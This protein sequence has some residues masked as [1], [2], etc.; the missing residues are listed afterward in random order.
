MTTF[1]K[2]T[3][4]VLTSVL[5]LSLATFA[6]AG[7]AR[8]GDDAG[9]VIAGLVGLAVL[10]AVISEIEKDNR[11]ARHAPAPVH[12][13]VIKP[14]P[15]PQDVHGRRLPL[16]CVRSDV[17][18]Q[19]NALLAKGCLKRHY[20]NADRLPR[21]CEVRYWNQKRADVRKGYTLNCLQHHGYRLARH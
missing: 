15:L 16:R 2:L 7:P 17:S 20:Q 8:A 13:P 18:Q 14:R 21:K 4:L 5:S 9:K 3:K 6:T 12:P 19:G 11:R 1:R 10:G